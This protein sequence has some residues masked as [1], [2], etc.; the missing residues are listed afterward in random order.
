M[1]EITLSVIIPVTRMSGKLSNL[2]KTFE[3]CSEKDIE[4]VIVHDEQDEDTQNE[5]EELITN[6]RDLRI[7]LFRKTFNSPG[8]ARNYGISKSIGLWF[9]F[10]DSDD[11]PCTSNLIKVAL[12]AD[13]ANADVGIGS[14]I[15]QFENRQTL[16]ESNFL[17]EISRKSLGTFVQNPSFTRFVF[18]SEKFKSVEFPKCRMAEDQVYL[19]RTNFLD[20]KIY[21][22]NLILYK[23]FVDLPNQATKNKKSLKELSD[24]L[25][26]L[27]ELKNL[28]SP[29]TNQ[30]I[31]MLLLKISLTCLSRRIHLRKA[32]KYVVIAVITN[33]R[34]SFSI[35]LSYGRVKIANR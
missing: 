30:L 25:P 12:N 33:P 27:Y 2:K 4:F 9:C 6:F 35:F 14:L 34:D 29:K 8:M 32:F 23:Y 5:L 16:V 13:K 22:S 18:K 21:L 19:A 20:H 15:I 24:S 31:W 3:D 7:R 26:L 17:K 11:V 1:S 28:G 10:S